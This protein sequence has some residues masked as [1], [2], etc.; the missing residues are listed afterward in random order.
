MQLSLSL[1]S[2]VVV[3]AAGVDDHQKQNEPDRSGLD[4]KTEG[5]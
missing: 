1:S 5:E 3:A 2:P 4:P